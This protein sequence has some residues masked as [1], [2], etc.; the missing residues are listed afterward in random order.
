[1]YENFKNRKNLQLKKK[2][3]EKI[4]NQKYG[5]FRIQTKI[6]LLPQCAFQLSMAVQFGNLH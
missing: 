3:T 4:K 2:K 1:M 5:R 6:G